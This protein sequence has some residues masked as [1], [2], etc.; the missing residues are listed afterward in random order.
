[1]LYMYREKFDFYLFRVYFFFYRL[2]WVNFLLKLCVMFRMRGD[3]EIFESIGLGR[4]FF[5]LV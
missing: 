2:S 4:K 5:K 3:F 1:M